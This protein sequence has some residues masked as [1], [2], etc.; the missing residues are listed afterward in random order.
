M[1]RVLAIARGAV[2]GSIVMACAAGA[3]SRVAARSIEIEDFEIS[4]AVDHAGGL[5]VTKT[6]RLKFEGAWNGIIRSIPLQNVTSRGERRS[7][8]VRLESVTDQAGRRLDV[9]T[10]RRGAD[11]DLK[12]WV[13]GAS[14]AVSVVTIR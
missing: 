12:I 14:S 2:I 1:L 5:D 7:L 3:A 8:G 4:V 13:P 9:S 6:L 10:S 11:I